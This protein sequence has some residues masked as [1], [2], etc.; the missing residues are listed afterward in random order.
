MVFGLTYQIG[1]APSSIGP[2]GVM[3]QVEK[4]L[5]AFLQIQFQVVNLPSVN[6]IRSCFLIS[7]TTPCRDNYFTVSKSPES[8]RILFE[9]EPGGKTKAACNRNYYH[10]RVTL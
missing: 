6:F 4:E 10:N 1:N 2:P 9:V 8:R 7:F 5:G 3:G